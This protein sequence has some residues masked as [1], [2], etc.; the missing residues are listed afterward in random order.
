[1]KYGVVYNE[2]NFKFRLNV[3]MILILVVFYNLEGYDVYFFMQVMFI[4]LEEINIYEKKFG[5]LYFIV[6]KKFQKFNK[7][8]GIRRLLLKYEYMDFFESFIEIKLFVFYF[9]LIDK[10][11]IKEKYMSMCRKYGKY[12]GVKILM[13]ILICM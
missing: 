9:K 10:N 11:I 5:K 1:M 2:C 7:E 3:K 4:E 6:I 8:E 12:L 13:N